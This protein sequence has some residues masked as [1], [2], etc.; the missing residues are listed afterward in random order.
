MKC[1][2]EAYSAESA[3]SSLGLNVPDSGTQSGRLSE[4]STADE[5]SSGTGRTSRGSMMFG[6]S[7]VQLSLPSISY[8]VDSH[9]KM[10]PAQARALVLL[11]SARACGVSMLASSGSFARSGSL[12]KMSFP[13][14]PDGSMPSCV[15]WNSLA[16]RRFLSLSRLRMSALLTSE[17]ASSSLPTLPTPTVCGNY[18]RKGASATSGDG[19][20]TAAGGPLNPA[21]VEWLMG[22]LLGHTDLEL[23]ETPSSRRVPKSSVGS[24]E[25]C[26]KVEG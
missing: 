2:S 23:S 1:E 13:A 15:S 14:R 12:L 18:N 11:E 10:C 7:E 17:N 3:D 5:C 21:W 22:F 19:L 9:A 8:V 24:L 20:A 4:T 16:M 26:Q 6:R 25:K